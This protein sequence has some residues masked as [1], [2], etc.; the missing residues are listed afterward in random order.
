MRQLPV[1]LA[2]RARLPIMCIFAAAADS[3]EMDMPITWNFV[4]EVPYG[5][6]NITLKGIF[7][8]LTVRQP[9]FVS[10]GAFWLSGEVAPPVRKYRSAPSPSPNIVPTDDVRYCPA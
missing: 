5:F 3:S 2:M 6:S 9:N 10:F 7:C 4:M 8:P 1:S